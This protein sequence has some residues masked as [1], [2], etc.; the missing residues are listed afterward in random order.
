M[1]RTFL[2]LALTIGMALLAAPFVMSSLYIDDRDI[3]IPGHIH[4]KSER[5]KMRYS[6]WTR[7]AAITVEYSDPETGGV[8]FFDVPLDSERFDGFR[9]GQPVPLHYLRARDMPA[10]PLAQA[11]RGIHLLPTVRLADQRAFSGLTRVLAAKLPLRFQTLA[12]VVIFL[13]LWRVARWP[14][15]VWAFGVVFFSGALSLLIL[16]FPRPTPRPAVNVRQASGT[17]K[18]IDQIDRLFSGA[19]TKGWA[20]DQPVAV[21]GVEFVPAGRTEAVLAVDLIDA[22]S[23]PGLQE[24]SVVGIEYEAGH[25]RTAY[26]QNASRRFVSRNVAGIVMQGAACLMVLMVFSAVVYCFR[27]AF[28]RLSAPR[29]P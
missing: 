23:I 14:G 16:D 6:D 19:H 18:S 1:L 10:L 5:V 17:V 28:H 27:R 25:P 29:Q 20:A 12:A 26:L 9:I 3:T 13:V 24:K 4:A 8:S 21:V 7:A 22:G 11:F 15:F 2:L